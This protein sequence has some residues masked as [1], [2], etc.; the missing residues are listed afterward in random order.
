MDEHII[1]T[2]IRK[3][4]MDDILAG[5]IKLDAETTL[6]NAGID[7]FSMIE[8]LLFIQSKYNMLVP[9]NELTPENFRTLSALARL[10]NKLSV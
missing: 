9:D 2:D 6:Q 3:F 7:S 1:V 10:V 5:G 4:I 8:I